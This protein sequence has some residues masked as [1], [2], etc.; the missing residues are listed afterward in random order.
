MDARSSYSA[1]QRARKSGLP[2]RC[3]DHPTRARAGIYSISPSCFAYQ[4]G[5]HRFMQRKRLEG[6]PQEVSGQE[7]AAA[8]NVEE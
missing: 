4:R 7:D 2:Y 5:T 6:C 8:V 1:H 3:R